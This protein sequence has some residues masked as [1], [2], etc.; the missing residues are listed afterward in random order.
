MSHVLVF[1]TIHGLGAPV[2]WIL[3][4]GALL[5]G[6]RLDQVVRFPMIF[7][8]GLC[9]FAIQ[10]PATLFLSRSFLFQRT[11]AQKAKIVCGSWLQPATDRFYSV[12]VAAVVWAP[13][14]CCTQKVIGRD[15]WEWDAP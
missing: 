9:V 4:L 8:S 13:R 12:L 2:G 15:V 3:P 5:Y 1:L 11:S 14:M 6:L 10:F 7:Q